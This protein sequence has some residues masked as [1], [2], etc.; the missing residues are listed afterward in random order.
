MPMPIKQP[1]VALVTGAS[2]GM[3]KDFALRLHTHSLLRERTLRHPDLASDYDRFAPGPCERSCDREIDDAHADGKAQP[4][5]PSALCS[6]RSVPRRYPS[7]GRAHPRRLWKDQF[8][9]ARAAP[10]RISLASV[11]K[12]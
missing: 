8:G 10:C 4:I 1:L 6:W 3:G 9:Y 11:S 5:H 2:S 12:S 7:A